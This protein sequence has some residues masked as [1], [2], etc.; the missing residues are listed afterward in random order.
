MVL[1]QAIS[2]PRD[3]FLQEKAWEAVCPLVAKLKMFYE[4]S[5]KLGKQLFYLLAVH[6]NAFM[7][8]YSPFNK[9]QIRLSILN[10]LTLLQFLSFFHFIKKGKKQCFVI[11][12][13]KNLFPFPKFPLIPQH[14]SLL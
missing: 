3:E 11:V 9:L 2:N 5:L 4:F 8:F 12:W 7:S 6:V 13:G 1:F 10:L 14:S